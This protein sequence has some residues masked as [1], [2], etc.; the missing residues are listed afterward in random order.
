MRIE[1]T[2]AQLNIKVTNLSLTNIDLHYKKDNDELHKNKL[3]GIV[4]NWA[5]SHYKLN[6]II[7]AQIPDQRGQIIGG[8]IDDAIEIYKRV[9]T[10]PNFFS[11]I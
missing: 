1:E 5:H 2:L 7:D 4:N 9:E 6:K 11:P 3:W 10:E 8:N